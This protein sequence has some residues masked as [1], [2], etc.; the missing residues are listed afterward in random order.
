MMS[1][2][3]ISIIAGCHSPFHS[4]LVLLSWRKL[5]GAWPK[6]W[7]IVCIFLHDVGHIG[8]DYLDDFEQKKKHWELGARIGERLFGPK[9]FDFLA[10]HCSHSGHPLSELYKPDKY[11]WHIAP[12]WWLYLNCIFEPK[13]SMGYGKW[14]AVARFKAQVKQSVESG[15]YKSTHSMYMERCRGGEGDERHLKFKEVK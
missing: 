5:Y 12:R 14:E 1:Q 13:I 8:L 10:G 6:P 2:G 7:Q 15:E 4:V 11:S 9:A 3:T